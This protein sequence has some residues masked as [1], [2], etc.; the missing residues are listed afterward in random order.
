MSEL[1]KIGTSAVLGNQQRLQNTS[2][3][4]SNI[5]TPGYTRQRTEF[6]SY[7]EWGIGRSETVRLFDKF[8]LDQFRRD[9]TSKAYAE[10]YQENTDIADNLFSDQSTS[11]AAGLG[12]VFTRLNE[13]NDEPNSITPRQLA[14]SDSGALVARMQSLSERVLDQEDIVNDEIKLQAVETNA[15]LDSLQDINRKIVLSEGANPGSAS[16]ELLDQRNEMVR[17][18]SEKVDIKTLED[19]S[20]ALLVNLK[21]GEPL[22]IES[23]V[24]HIK[25]VQGDPDPERLDL[26]LQLADNNS[27]TIDPS[28]NEFGGTLGALTDYR[29]NV[30][31]ESINSLG[32]LAIAFSD[33]M[34]EQNK[35]GVDLDGN[36]G[37]AMFNIP[38]TTALG[39]QDNSSDFHTIEAR[40]EAGKGGEMTNFNYE[41]VFTSATEYTIQ[42]IDAGEPIA[43]STSGPFTIP[44][45]TTDFQGDD[46]GLPDGL[47]L[48]FEPDTNFTAGDTFLV[49]PT[50]LAGVEIDLAISRPEQ[51]AM[52]APVSVENPISNIGNGEIRL[53]EIED[54]NTD[55]TTLNETA[56][57]TGNTL[58]ADAPVTVSYTLTGEYEV[59]DSTGAVIGTVASGQNIMEQ[60]RQAGT[61]GHA[62][63]ADGEYVSGSHGE[64]YP[65]YEISVDGSPEPGDVFNVSYNTNGFDNNFN[66][67]QL[68]ELQSSNTMRR[69]I[70]SSGNGETLTFAEAYSN[71]IGFVG[72]TANRA[73]IELTTTTS[74]LSQSEQRV[75]DMSGVNLDEEAAD[76][77]R[78][79]QAY[80]AAARIITVAQTT[81]DSILQAVR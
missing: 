76:L 40:V 1:L 22:V 53:T 70:A 56:F 19:S 42:P 73:N 75:A 8:A 43:G 28:Q 27:I 77:V 17:Q 61:W 5:N 63:N 23:G 26:Q 48:R 55:N 6:T 9:T 47:E 41:V 3:N 59:Q 78:F 81:F 25:A 12:D 50:R 2:N 65:G 49:R 46:D 44:G 36:L 64:D 10:K 38:S 39:Y 29:T 51:I 37:S 80:N 31:D 15:I 72:D 20:G 14:I 7:V 62:L 33:A 13:A 54:T 16:P 21:S 35:L 52:A 24:F 32:Q 4:I 18:L 60:L 58:D 45:N 79:E 69:N 68:A 71:I 57:A 34:N 74:L 67:I 30:L 11:I 66:G